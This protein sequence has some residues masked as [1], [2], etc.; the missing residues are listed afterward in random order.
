MKEGQ[1]E[2][3]S[4]SLEKEQEKQISIYN[5][6]IKERRG[7]QKKTKATRS[8][9]EIGIR[10]DKIQE[11]KQRNEET[12][13]AQRRQNKKVTKQNRMYLYLYLF[14]IYLSIYLSIY[15]YVYIYQYIYI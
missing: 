9:K 13:K 3:D 6:K 14:Y 5:R 7:Q 4:R 2:R 1:N 15:L 12:V 8:Q 11:R 10:E